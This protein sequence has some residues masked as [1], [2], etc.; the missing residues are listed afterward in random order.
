MFKKIIFYIKIIFSDWVT[1]TPVNFNGMTGR[2]LAVIL[3]LNFW[4]SCDHKK[5]F[6]IGPQPNNFMV[7]PIVVVGIRDCWWPIKWSDKM[8]VH[9][10]HAL[11]LGLS[12]CSGHPSKYWLFLM[13]P[14]TSVIEGT[15]A[16]NIAY[17]R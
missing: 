10:M 12:I 7:H 2:A 4:K 11:D 9:T 8:P 15:G 16:F 6:F 14:K 3:K 5:R 1:G 17:G 13:L